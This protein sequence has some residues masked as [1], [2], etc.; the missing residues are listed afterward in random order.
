MLNE[1]K[2]VLSN[3]DLNT[4]NEIFDDKS[5]KDKKSEL[6]KEYFDKNKNGN[7]KNGGDF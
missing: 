7:I 6:E 4:L 5:K 3:R 2:I 1:R